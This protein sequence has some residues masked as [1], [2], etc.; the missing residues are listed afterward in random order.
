MKKLLDEI[1]LKL[2]NAEEKISEFKN[3][4]IKTVKTEAQREKKD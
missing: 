1:N 3:I 2:E 4:E